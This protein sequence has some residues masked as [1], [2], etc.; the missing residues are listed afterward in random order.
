MTTKQ[1]PNNH[2]QSTNNKQ[3]QKT[4]TN[5]HCK[6]DINNKQTSTKQ[7]TNK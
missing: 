3:K 6:N 2:M 1:Q 5:M 7:Q 4:T